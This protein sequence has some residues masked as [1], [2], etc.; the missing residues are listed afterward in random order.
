LFGQVFVF[1]KLKQA[2]VKKRKE[3]PVAPEA[4]DAKAH[5]EKIKSMEQDDASQK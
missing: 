5:R 1:T 4:F 3:K 2:W